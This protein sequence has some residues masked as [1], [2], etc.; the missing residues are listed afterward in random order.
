MIVHDEIFRKSSECFW[1]YRNG[2]VRR[3]GVDVLPRAVH[4][5]STA[6][7]RATS[8]ARAHVVCFF[9]VYLFVTFLRSAFFPRHPTVPIRLLLLFS[10]LCRVRAYSFSYPLIP[11][12]HSL[13]GGRHPLSHSPLSPRQRH[14]EQADPCQRAHLLPCRGREA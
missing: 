14:H 8:D 11:A 2:D 9:P 7:R 12:S 5:E 10:F 6:A 4:R 13:H 1:V 3:R